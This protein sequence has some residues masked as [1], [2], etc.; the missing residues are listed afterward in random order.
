VDNSQ[1]RSALGFDDPKLPSGAPN[2]TQIPMPN[3]THLRPTFRLSSSLC[4]M[5]ALLCL[6]P[7]LNGCM[8]EESVPLALGGAGN[9]DLNDST[10]G[11]SAISLGQSVELE[12]KDGKT[13][14][15]RGGEITPGEYELV[16]WRL[17]LDP[18][19][20]TYP[21]Q[22]RRTNF[23]FQK[24]GVL[25]VRTQGQTSSF[26]GSGTYETEGNLLRMSYE[27]PG[28]TEPPPLPYQATADSLTILNEDVQELIFRRIR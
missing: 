28:R 15:V 14:E 7:N 22:F 25:R 9:L 23:V 26:V 21:T 17:W 16:T 6:L 4:T 20:G 10:C 19:P 12:L 5:A 3:L 11:T 13:P 2:L 8:G 1:Y 24:D 27:C 18:Q